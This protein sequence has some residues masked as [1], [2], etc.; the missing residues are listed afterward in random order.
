MTLVLLTA[1]LYWAKEV[2]I[3]V[4]LAILLAF[5]L[6]PVISALQRFRLGRVPAVIVVVILTSALLGGIGWTVLQQVASLTNDI[7]RYEDNIKQ[8][9]AALRGAGKGS[10]IEKA[11]KTAEN[12]MEE[13]QKDTP[14]KE[15]GDKPVPVVVQGPSVFWQLPTLLEEL[16]TAGL[17]MVLAIFMLLDRGDMRNRLIRLVGLSRLTT[18]TQ[19]LNE[20]GRRISRYLLMQ[21]II[22]GS[23][24]TIVG[25]V[26]FL[27][28]LPHAVLWGF[29]AAVL[30]FIPYVGV[31]VAILLPS[32]LSLAVFP[33]WTKPFLVL[34]IIVPVEFINSMFLEP[35][36]YGQSI[37]VSE[38]ALLVAIAFWTWLWGPLGLLL[39]T[40]LTVS[41]VV[42][43]KYVPQLEFFSVLMGDEPVMEPSTHYY[44]RLVAHDQDEAIEI[45]DDYLRT[46][47]L[48]ETYETVLIP[49][50]YTAQ[51]DHGR[52]HLSD[53]DLHFIGQATQEIVDDVGM[54]AA[55][56][57]ASAS[58]AADAFTSAEQTLTSLPQVRLVAAPVRGQI[59][60]VALLMLAQHLDPARYEIEM[61]S[62]TSLASEVVASVEQ[63]QVGIVYLGGVAPGG[64][65]QLR[66]LCKRLRIQLPEIKIVVGR[67]GIPENHD[68]MRALLQAA[69]ADYV[70]TTL[71][72]TCAQIME[73]GQLLA[74]SSPPA[75]PPHA[76]TS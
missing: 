62:A 27:L 75:D 7:A 39:A 55:P 54:H 59:D 34:G 41:I 13:L 23:F 24:G 43:G 56:N 66:Y 69:G 49:A 14:T 22:N 53:E 2:V 64:M 6:E 38:I 48:E 52:H 50:L 35:Y 57:T 5:L 30:R 28:G 9:I 65:A 46:H 42:L 10:F 29:L 67:W 11:Q 1:V 40:P 45:V 44:Q 72:E 33:G 21:S 74:A 16:A 68:K 63:Q 71:H 31:T 36:L 60:A 25:L 32:L 37:G 17:V 76:A 3:P 4:A 70:G 20:A 58:P 12:V 8:K 51:K 61:L 18:T 73:V 19:A 47:S 15:G 26:L